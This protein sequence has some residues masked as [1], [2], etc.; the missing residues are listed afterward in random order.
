MK[1]GGDPE[2]AGHV[3]ESL[4]TKLG[5]SEFFKVV[6]RS[7]L[8]QVVGE[9]RRGLSDLVDPKTAAEAGRLLG[10]KAVVVGQVVAY[11]IVDT[12]YTKQVRKRVG[13]GRFRTIGSGRRARKE[14]IMKEVL[15]TEKHTRREG[16]LSVS[17]RVVEVATG[18]ILASRRWITP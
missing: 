8:D 2:V 5:E 12:P 3:T 14:E 15:V 13:T 17:L 6:E 7:R 16:V 1:L 18:R 10:V 9:I 11:R 4:T